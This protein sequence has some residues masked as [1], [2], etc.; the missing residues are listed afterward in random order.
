MKFLIAILLIIVNI[1]AIGQDSFIIHKQ[2]INPY[3]KPKDMIIKPNG[4]MIF[5]YTSIPLWSNDIDV[6][7]IYEI[8]DN[9][10]VV[11]SASYTDTNNKHVES[12]HC[13]FTNDT[14]YIF[15]SGSNFGTPE[16]AFIF[17][18]KYD[19][20]Y[21]LIES[22]K[23]NSVLNGFGG[24]LHGK[25][26]FINDKFYYITAAGNQ[27]RVAPLCAVISKQGQL[28]DFGIDLNFPNTDIVPFDFD[29]HIFD[30]GYKIFA[31]TLGFWGAPE[32]CGL[33]CY[34]SREFQMEDFFLLPFEMD[35]YFT[36]QPVNDS[37]FYIAGEWK[38]WGS[39]TIK[40][41]GILKLMNDTTVVNKFLYAAEPDSSAC[42]AYRNSLEI[43]PDGNLIFCFTD[44]IDVETFPTLS[45]TKINLM[46]LTPDFDII[47]HRYIGDGI[48]S[49]HAWVMKV[50]EAEEIIIHGS[51][52][53]PDISHYQNRDVLFI[54]TTKNGLI[55]GTN[56]EPSVVR[57]TEAIVYPNP[58]ADYIQV[59]F[60]MAHNQATFSLLDISGKTV[61]KKQLTTNKQS[62][63]ISGIPAG[64]YIYR[65]FNTKGL[66]EKGKLM[67]E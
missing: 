67:V 33:I 40:R 46:K 24:T 66:D 35:A 48:N 17:M 32:V 4:N 61:F 9:G 34:F 14:L 64:S 1:P 29:N 49:W 31:G 16:D 63:D 28:I 26:K 12:N 55:T 43:L 19:L 51:Y 8:N 52:H 65:V 56:D 18:L 27:S 7:Y 20:Q 60:S 10:E 15:G 21:N 36:Y 59:E 42:P 39:S 25:H 47:W 44:N 54:K 37:V 50:N 30:N 62:L 57:S 2:G 13:V 53:I 45:P 5:L 38:D 58:A 6:N 23:Y 41:A 22:F 11:G 3:N